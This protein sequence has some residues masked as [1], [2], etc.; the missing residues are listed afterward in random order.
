M[1]KTLSANMI[2]MTF[3]DAPRQP[4]LAR[5]PGAI[6]LEDG[7][8]SFRV[9]APR[10]KEVGVVLVGSDAPTQVLKAAGNGYF[11]AILDGVPP[12]TRYEFLLDGSRRRPDPASR[13][14]PDGVHGASQVFH[15]AQYRRQNGG[16]AGL[17]L[18][19]YVLYELH[20]GTFTREGTFAAVIPRLDEIKDLGVTAIEIMPVAQFPGN[21]NWGYDGV[22]PYAVQNSYG[23]PLELQ[24]LVDA[25]HARGLAAVLDVV[26]NHLG[27]EGNYHAEFAPY[28]T[29]RYHTPWGQALNFDGPGSDEVVR[30]FV[31]NALYWLREMRFDALRLD[32]IHSI[33][34]RNARPFLQILSAQVEGLRAETG[35]QILLIAESDLNDK[36][37]ILPRGV[38]GLGMDAQWSDDFH[39]SLHAC[40][41]REDSGYYADYTDPTCLPKSINE[42]YVYAGQ[43][44]QSRGRRHGNPSADLPGQQF[45]ICTQ[46]H[47]QVGNRMLG[48]RLSR[49]VS[50]DALKIAAGLLLFSP[51]VPLIFMGEEY[52]ETAPFQYF[53][54]HSDGDL[55]EAVRKGRREEFAAFGWKGEAP[56][57][58]SEATFAACVLHWSLRAQSPHRE[59]LAF[60]RELL[61]LRRTLPA[62][63]RLDKAASQAEMLEGTSA[64]VLHRNHA[65][66]P[67]IAIF[68]LEGTA[69]QF[70]FPATSGSWTNLLDSR[71]RRF[72]GRGKSLPTV[73][74][75]PASTHLTLDGHQMGLFVRT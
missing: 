22:A 13:F 26:Y 65:A 58:Q 12:G 55:I 72:G 1:A 40:L 11:E 30:Y 49:L 4:E 46:N 10:C 5:Q 18:D 19:K 31:E 44:S 45:V 51:A 63:Q 23:G 68:N 25:C 56:D 75:E 50:F 28:F 53:T 16:W 2:T 9:W 29:N 42:G 15:P 27:P 21:C 3:P 8:V 36:R 52:G 61:N 62:L 20:V 47:D 64:L 60:Y 69:S 35:R 37:V 54:S 67:V 33:V 73:I 32:A 17:A 7:R 71:D 24:K 70:L 74:S 39:H 14:Q 6:V 43:Y 48:E 59:L 57:P 66:Q 34:D 41:T 38:E